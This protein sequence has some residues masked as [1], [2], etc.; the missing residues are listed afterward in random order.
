MTSIV[1]GS[2][3]LPG[4]SGDRLVSKVVSAA[5]AA[6]FKRTDALE[7]NVK[8]EPVAKL[9]QGSVDG[10]DLIGKGLQMHNGL[11]IAVMELFVNAVAIDFGAILSGQVK[12]K[13]PTEASLRVV[14][15]EADLTESFNTPFIV[16]K[17]QR[18]EYD[19]EPLNFQN[20]QMGVNDDRTISLTSS[21]R[22]GKGDA[23]ALAMTAAVEVIDRRKIQFVEVKHQGNED[24]ET[25]GN[26]LIEHVNSML[27][28][29]RFALDGMQLRVDRLRV[30]P[31][32]IVFYGTAAIAQFP[33]RRAA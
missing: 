1:F 18:L 20:T 25:L 8:A 11:R 33:K 30:Q 19:G 28:L 27:D 9:L 32:Q 13:Q 17:L 31:Q 16:E 5:I 12:I 14:L 26:A 6:F 7:A 2:V 15:T 21:V 29:E 22:I 10:F 23:I 3:P 4:Q 24:A